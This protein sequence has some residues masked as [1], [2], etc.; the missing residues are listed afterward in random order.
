MIPRLEHV[1]QVWVT[2]LLLQRRWVTEDLN[3][4]CIGGFPSEVIWKYPYLWRYFQFHYMFSKDCIIS[5]KKTTQIF[6]WVA[7]CNSSTT[8]NV[9]H[10]DSSLQDGITL[11]HLNVLL[12]YVYT[13]MDHSFSRI[14]LKNKFIYWFISIFGCVGSSLL[15]VGFSLVVASGG[16]SSLCCTGFSLRWRLLLQSTG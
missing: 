16:Y 8:P 14:F 6:T 5:P 3:E 2:R 4:N 1:C 11:V 9:M 15:H 10:L 7:E 12:F 13:C